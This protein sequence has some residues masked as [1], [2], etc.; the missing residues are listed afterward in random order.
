MLSSL[1]D[2]S[3]LTT[4]FIRAGVG[5]HSHSHGLASTAAMP[6]CVVA[7]AA[8]VLLRLSVCIA[9]LLLLA[10]NFGKLLG[11]EPTLL[12]TNYTGSAS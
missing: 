11:K 5:C 12:T 9:V 10:F 6:S 7:A 4:T 2:A 8:V 3:R 1:W